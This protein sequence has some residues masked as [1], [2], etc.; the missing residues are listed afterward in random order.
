MTGDM[1]S[2]F[3]A[4]IELTDAGTDRVIKKTRQLGQVRIVA[5]GSKV[6]RAQIV[7]TIETS[8]IQSGCLLRRAATP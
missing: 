1:L 4:P 5:L 3:S 8:R 2:V 6:S 7:E